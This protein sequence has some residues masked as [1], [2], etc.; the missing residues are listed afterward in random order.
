MAVG[1]IS[2][3]PCGKRIRFACRTTRF[4]G[5]G[6]IAMIPCPR[7][8]PPFQFVN[9][10]VNPGKQRLQPVSVSHHVNGIGTVGMDVPHVFDI[11][12]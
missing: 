5:L 2:G 7:T 3:N 1:P 11:V 9:G 10:R 4:S 8:E 12:E 6:I